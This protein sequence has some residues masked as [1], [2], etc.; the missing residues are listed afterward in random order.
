M[1]TQLSGFLLALL[2]SQKFPPSYPQ[3]QSTL[4]MRGVTEGIREGVLQ[5]LCSKVHSQ[6][7]DRT[8]QWSL[9]RDRGG[10]V[11]DTEKADHHLCQQSRVPGP[12]SPGAD[13]ALGYEPAH[14][15]TKSRLQMC[16]HCYQAKSD[17]A[18]KYSY[19]MTVG[20]VTAVM[21]EDKN[22]N[23]VNIGH[24]CSW[25]E[26]N[27]HTRTRT[28]THAHYHTLTCVHTDTHTQSPCTSSRC[29]YVNRAHTSL[30]FLAMLK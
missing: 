21:T 28:H 16:D 5:G 8:G 4:S 2:L 3:W 19:Q 27:R 14:R 10:K 18:G 1:R 13:G 12:R 23:R 17:P 7:E 11:A 22:R 9:G 6:S 29:Y 30:Y 26:V 25:G 20:S 15:A 24:C